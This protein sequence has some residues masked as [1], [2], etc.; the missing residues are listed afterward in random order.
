M[1]TPTPTNVETLIIALRTEDRRAHT[2]V[3]DDLVKVGGAAVEPLLLALEDS[4]PNVRAGAARALGKIG[5]PRA[6][7]ALIACL[8][9][10]TSAEVRKSAVWAL[11]MG[12]VRSVMPLIEA[13]H[14]RDEWVRFGATIVLAKIGSPAVL[15]L[16]R[17]TQRD[18]DPRVRAIAAETL[19]RIGD[20]RALEVLALGLKDPHENVWQQSAIALGRM[21]DA[22]AVRPLIHILLSPAVDLHTKAIKALGYIGDVRAVEPL[23]DQVYENGDRWVRLFAIEALGKISDLR[24]IEVLVDAALYDESQ[25]VRIKAIVT[26]GELPYVLAQDALAV[27]AES[28]E[29]NL[30]CHQTAVF[31]LGKRGDE[32]AFDG[33]VDMLFHSPSTDTR[34]YAALVLGEM[35]DTRAVTPLLSALSDDVPEVA[36]QV[37][38]VLTRIGQDATE[39]LV[40]ALAQTESAAERR[41]LVRVLGEVGNTQAVDALVALTRNM[42]ETHEIRT[43]AHDILR[44]LGYNRAE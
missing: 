28:E 11:H 29:T 40:E 9:E 41:W 36:G 8:R 5:D 33:L 34:I 38:R 4:N 23:I 32:R 35:G 17:T 13:L 44:R 31:E 16:I 26:L 20:V 12:D 14:D 6:L 24:S 2:L 42:N 21:A 37:V 22:R 43:E 39:I 10:D 1:N 19:G 27:I 3:V 18:R 15:P 25:D 30:N 7:D